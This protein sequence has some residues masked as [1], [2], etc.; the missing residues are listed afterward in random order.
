MQE[1][2]YLK[3]VNMENNNFFECLVIKPGSISDIS[4]NDPDY[5]KK[6]MELNLFEN[7]KTNS[8]SFLDMWGQKLNIG[9]YSNIKNIQVKNQIFDEEPYYIYEISYVDLENYEEYH[10]EKNELASLLNINGET[11][12]SNAIIFRNYIP[13]LSNS[14]TLCDVTKKD[15]ERILYNRVNTKVILYNTY[16][17]DEYIEK[18]I[19]GDLNNYANIFFEGDN[20]EKKEFGFLMYNINIWYVKD[21]DNVIGDNI[22]KNIFNKTIEKFICFTMK[23]EEFRGN[24][25]LDEFKKISFLSKKLNNYETPKEFLEEKNDNIGRKIINNKYKVLDY[26]YNLYN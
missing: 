5:T 7:V 20:Y 6:L 3:N 8:E 12:Y 25:S 16:I 19:I 4:W 26:L 17:N 21:S 14:M 22:F 13:S 24:L 9:K 11:I 2:N 23:S 18:E 15:I 1:E 10:E